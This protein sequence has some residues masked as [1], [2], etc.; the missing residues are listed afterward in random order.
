VNEVRQVPP[1]SQLKK[2]KAPELPPPVDGNTSTKRIKASEPG[3]LLPNWKQN[4][5]VGLLEHVAYKHPIEFIASDDKD[6]VE[7]EF[8]RSEGMKM[9]DAVRAAKPSTVRVD[10]SDKL[11]RV[12]QLSYLIRHTVLT[13][14]TCR[15][16]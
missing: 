1:P 12:L 13:N 10:Y 7:G 8:D 6:N 14:C 16:A 2:R 5:S 11:V 9:L 15:L 3:G 4:A